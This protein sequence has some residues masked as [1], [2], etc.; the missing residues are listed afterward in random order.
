MKEASYEHP[1]HSLIMDP[2]DKIWKN[3]FTDAELKK[4]PYV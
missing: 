2:R 1:V 3:Y 4:N